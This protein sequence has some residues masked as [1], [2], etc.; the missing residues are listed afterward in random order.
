LAG[1]GGLTRREWLLLGLGGAALFVLTYLTEPGL[2]GTIDWVRIHVFYKH[3]LAEAVR[4]GRLPLWNPHIALGRPFLADVDAA[5][6]YPPNVFYL[7][8]PAE[9]ACA[10][11]TTLHLVLGL[12]G[13]T[14]FARALGASAQAS[15]AA[16][17]VFLSSAAIVGCFSS[18]LIHYGAALCYLPL[19]LWLAVRLQEGRTPARVAA[20]ALVLGLQLMGGHPQAS[21]L[22]GFG[23][24]VFLV[25]RR[26]ER[27]FVPA[28]A[29]AALDLGCL[30]IAAAGAVGLAG[31]TVLPLAELLGQSNRG[32]PSLEFAGSFA[33]PSFGWATLVVP[34]E[35]A[36]QFLSNAQL[37]AGIVPLLAGL[38][39][40]T[41]V[42][43]RNARAL[44][45][46]ALAAV[47]LAAGNA[48]PLFSLLYHL[49]PGL[50]TMRIP[51]RASVLLCAALA[52]SAALF[53][54]APRRAA[55][56]LVPA[57][58]A[59]T[60]AVGFVLWWPGF[61]GAGRV[62]GRAGLIVAS[63]ALLVLWQ[64]RGRA[65][66]ALLLLLTAG[67]LA[68]A[69]AQLKRQ[70]RDDPERPGEV[71]VARTLRD[72][73]L[74]GGPPPRVSIPK[75]YARENAGMLY[76]WSSYSVYASLNL[77]RVWTY[78][79][80]GL[81]LPVPIE[82]NTYPASEIFRRGPFP[83][84]SMSLVMGL[85]PATRQARLRAHPDP[86][87]YLASAAEVVPDWRQAVERMRAGHDFHRVALVE[88]P[89]DLPSTGSAPGSAAITAFAPETITIA[90]RAEVPALL[91]LA[92]PW[93][94]GWTATVDG[95][96]APCLPANAW[97]RAV[98]VPAG[99]H[100]VVLRFHSTRLRAG[101]VLSLLTLAAVLG[102]LLESRLRRPRRVR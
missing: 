9:V 13:M 40:L 81:G 89:V 45:L 84:D 15:L 17:F 53:V 39:G 34:S 6:F 2:Y 14:R 99:M 64:R 57:A 69:I 58:L 38:G 36:F 60:A 62:I 88:A 28:L 68:F 55:L 72:A 52:A 41:L 23:A 12:H 83:Y 7:F 21:W 25:G 61:S 19:V 46:L 20:L 76:G 92:E 71:A 33:M 79:H 86:R 54:S 24:A 101:A 31:V 51:S 29:A 63:A 65:A 78:L 4:A 11:V 8:L 30:V 50:S 1:E 102:V 10:V 5:L 94:P 87:A 85:D 32:A 67:D 56:V 75:P 26:M 73:Q 3:Y 16:A 77:G 27:P 96:A 100:Q 18:G 49:V 37:Y 48:T 97:M 95:A 91:V 74:E 35:D 42:R 82:Q 93:Y 70:N 22:T 44:G 80:A 43:D 47:V 59:L 90:T 98:P 66:G